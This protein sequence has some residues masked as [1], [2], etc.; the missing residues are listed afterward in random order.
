MKQCMKAYS[1]YRTV[2]EIYLILKQKNDSFLNIQFFMEV[3]KSGRT[4]G[5]YDYEKEC[6]VSHLKQVL[7]TY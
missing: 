2:I 4:Q 1:G 7:N 5:H 3:F 6:E